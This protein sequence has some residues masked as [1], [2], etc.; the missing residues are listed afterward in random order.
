MAHSGLSPGQ[1]IGDFRVVRLLGRGSTGTVYEATH[2]ESGLRVAAKVLSPAI[3]LDPEIASRFPSLARSI[4]LVRHPGLAHL[5]AFGVRPDR[6]AFLVTEFLEGETLRERLNQGPLSE[7]QALRTARQIA[8]ALSVT[9][10]MG[11]LNLHPGNIMLVPGEGGEVV[12]VLDFGVARI[13]G[14]APG[15]EGYRSP[16]Q[17]AGARIDSRTDVYAL[18]ALLHTMLVGLPPTYGIS[19]LVTGE[20]ARLMQA[21]LSPTLGVRPAM[22]D[23]AERLA[24][25]DGSATEGGEGDSRKSTAAQAVLG[26]STVWAEAISARRRAEKGHHRGTVSRRVGRAVLAGVMLLLALVSATVVVVRK[27]QLRE[28]DEAARQP[29]ASGAAALQVPQPPAPPSM[30]AQ[31]PSASDVPSPSPSSE[32]RVREVRR[33]KRRK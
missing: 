11:H 22:R 16:E 17:A 14:S 28:L 25:L 21:M 23:I 33:G 26:R 18:A 29:P 15:A 19:S 13:A 31:P 7:I 10:E 5:I 1:S 9:E 30:H 2:R 6:M 4:S 12:K 20:V 24:Q 3:S 27:Q 8:E 32:Q